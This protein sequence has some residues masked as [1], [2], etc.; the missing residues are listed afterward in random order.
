MISYTYML[1]FVM[2]DLADGAAIF[3]RLRLT[4]AAR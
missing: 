4:S 2:D 3:P 1:E